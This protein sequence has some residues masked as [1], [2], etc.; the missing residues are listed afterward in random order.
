MRI[1][2][3]HQYYTTPEAGGGIRSWHI[4]QALVRAGHQVT[5]LCAHNG[6]E[7]VQE[8]HNGVTV[9]RFPVYYS[10]SLSYKER[11]R[12]FLHFSWQC[13]RYINANHHFDLVYASSTPLTVGVAALYGWQRFRLPFVFEVRDLWP[14]APLQA[15]AISKA[16]Y[17]VLRRFE[18]QLYQKAA[19]VVS[20][21]PEMTTHITGTQG[22]KTI[23]EVPN[24]ADTEFF[25][26]PEKN[27]IAPQ[28]FVCIGYFGNLGEANDWSSLARMVHLVRRLSLPIRFLVM[29][30]GTH[31][32]DLEDSS[33]RYPEITIMP[34]GSKQQVKEALLQTHFS[35]VLF[36]PTIP[37]LSSTSPN[38][39]FDSLAAGTPV[40]VNTPG[41]Q[42]EMV[43]YSQCGVYFLPGQE[44]AML[45]KL[46]SI[47][48][49][50]G[51]W[52]NYSHNARLMAQLNYSVKTQMPRL[53]GWLQS[54]TQ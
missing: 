39:L 12:S 30:D 43:D 9:V 23:I 21:S 54:L 1:L 2:Y 44:E 37:I 28:N 53:V 26:P 25:A 31:L 45:K 52:R 32:S 19:G 16:T 5:L 8:D 22:V 4:S 18:V 41:W 10:Q 35:L 20:L 46:L 17:S 7:Q 3:L 24:L 50:A 6:E 34:Y 13:C 40:V 11:I 48:F 42:K 51:I 47:C 49:K 15:G 27:R 36:N 29:A 33:G 38:K 14:L